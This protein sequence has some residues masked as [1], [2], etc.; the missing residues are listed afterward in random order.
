SKWFLMKFDL[1]G[2]SQWNHTSEQFLPSSYLLQTTDGGFV[3]ASTLKVNQNGDTDIYLVRTYANGTIQWNQTS[4]VDRYDRPSAIIQTADDGFVVAGISKF[5]ESNLEIS[6]INLIKFSDSSHDSG[7]SNQ[8][9]IAG[10]L[11]LTA[12]LGLGLYLLKFR[13]PK[14]F[15]QLG[16]N[17]TIKET[18]N[19]IFNGSIKGYLLLASGVQK[20]SEDDTIGTHIPK[21]LFKHKFLMHPV[22]LAMMKILTE[23][24]VVTSIE[25]KNKLDLS[26]G[27]FSHHLTNMKKHH[28]I[29]IDDKFID[30]I[31]KQAI[32]V[33][34]VGNKQYVN[35]VKILHEF[36]SSSDYN[37]FPLNFKSNHE[38]E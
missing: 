34:I 4:G 21:S 38:E 1:N 26:W 27:E 16:I 6:D 11:V 8:K 32:T 30:G 12:F 14:G 33:T 20:T 37:T 17:K 28:L 5:S 15:S 2:I 9:L 23:N 13:S 31:T 36:F 22:R 25:L 3:I 10:L 7:I 29:Q 24:Q 19:L 35:L 18:L